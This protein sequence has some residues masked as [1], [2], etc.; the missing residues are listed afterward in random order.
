VSAVSASAETSR[1]WRANMM[2]LVWP[3][4][5][6]NPRSRLRIASFKGAGD[7]SI[8]ANG[9]A[10]EAESPQRARSQKPEHRPL[11]R[12]NPADAA[13][14]ESATFCLAFCHLP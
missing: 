13:I 4:L 11:A 10:S 7:Q 2:I 14:D 1:P 9:A 8:R 3:D 6:D 12:S 5:S